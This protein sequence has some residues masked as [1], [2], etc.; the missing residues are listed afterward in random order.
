MWHKFDGQQG[1]IIFEIGSGPE[2]VD[3]IN[4]TAAL[5]LQALVSL[6]FQTALDARMPE[7]LPEVIFMFK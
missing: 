6:G 4:K 1:D 7:L 3:R 2:S 5:L